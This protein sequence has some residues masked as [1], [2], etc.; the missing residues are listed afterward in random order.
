MTSANPWEPR[1]IYFGEVENAIRVHTPPVFP[2][3]D[4]QTRYISLVTTSLCSIS[5]A[6][7]GNTFFDRL[8][9]FANTSSNYQV[10]VAAFPKE[11]AQ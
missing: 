1:N 8:Q 4:V 2:M 5:S 3:N 11:R 7:D 6:L 9:S 10:L